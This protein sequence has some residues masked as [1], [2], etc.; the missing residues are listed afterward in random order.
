MSLTHDEWADSNPSPA[1]AP[2]TGAAPS[3]A[4]APA[5]E[6]G[7][8]SGQGGAAS[9]QLV[10]STVTDFVHDYLAPMIRRNLA[11]G[12]L[13]WCPAWWRHPEAV[14]RLT[15][16]WRSWENLRLDPA[17]GISM[18]FLHHCD[19]HLRVLMD[20]DIGPLAACQPGQHGAYALAPLP[21]ERP[22]P[23][24]WLSPAFSAAPGSAE[25]DIGGS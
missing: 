19:P 4:P 14:T 5:A 15:A 20:P 1:S 10:F 7:S 6:S 3:A 8:A 16:L 13:T 2:P 9:P 25:R 22:D 24:L 12:Q 21:V 11:G 23:A 18:W 17:V